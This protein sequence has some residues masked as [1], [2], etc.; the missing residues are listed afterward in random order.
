MPA[1]PEPDWHWQEEGAFWADHVDISNFEQHLVGAERITFWNVMGEIDRVLPTLSKLWWLDLRGGSASNLEWIC[2]CVNLKYLM[3]NQIRGLSNVAF[4]GGLKNLQLL[5]LRAL[6]KVTDLPD[7][8]AL[9]A[10]RRVNLLAMNGISDVGSLASAPALTDLMVYNSNNIDYSSFDAFRNHKN[11]KRFTWWN[12][13]KPYL[14]GVL[15]MPCE[16]TSI[17]HPE[18]F[19]F[20]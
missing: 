2:N 20:R 16:R 11:L 8:S 12:E 10:L 19:P 3:L 13:R 4:I 7:C 18:Q 15:S 9:L 5:E 17:E 6:K 14:D 1:A